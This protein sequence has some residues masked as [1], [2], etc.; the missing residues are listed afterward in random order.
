MTQSRNTKKSW[1]RE[2][3]GVMLLVLLALICSF[4]YTNADPFFRVLEYMTPFVF[5]FAGGAF[6]VKAVLQ[7]SVDGQGK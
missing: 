7:Q 5:I 3:A 4:L 2:V 1:S 6:G